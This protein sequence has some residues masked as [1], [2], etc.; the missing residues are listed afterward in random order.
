METEPN[1]ELTPIEYPIADGETL[2]IFTGAPSGPPCVRDSWAEY[3]LFDVAEEATGVSI[4]WDE[5]P[6]PNSAEQLSLRVATGDLPDLVVGLEEVSGGLISAYDNGLI[7]DLSDYIQTCAP[8]YYTYTRITNDIEKDLLTDEGYE[9]SIH[10]I[11][12][13]LDTFNGMCLRKDWLDELGLDIPTTYNELYEVMS[14]I[15]NAYNPKEPISLDSTLAYKHAWMSAGYGVGNYSVSSTEML[16]SFYLKDGGDTVTIALLDEDYKDYISMLHSWYEAGF[17]TKDFVS[18][19][20]SENDILQLICG[21]DMAMCCISTESLA[22]YYSNANDEDFELVP[23]TLISED[24]TEE[25]NHF[26]LNYVINDNNVAVTTNCDDLELALKWINYWYTDEGIMLMNYGVEGISY[27]K[28]ADGSI[29]FTDVIVNNP[30]YPTM[31]VTGMLM[32]YN[33]QGKMCGIHM[34]YNKDAIYTEAQLN[35]MKVWSS[36]LDNAYSM[37]FG[38]SLTTEESSK[39]TGTFNDIATYASEQLLAFVTGDSSMDEWDRFVDT[40]RSMGLE[41]CVE[42]YQ[43]AYD[44]YCQRA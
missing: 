42:V 3:E 15:V 23:L 32:R 30:E 36:C 19:S 13:G 10:V 41:E 33:C 5:V 18:T 43:D 34:I 17:V 8:D 2:S 24:G 35:S 31:S 16:T 1:V 39:I 14:A 7:Y 4:E 27:T 28:E 20:N 26:C 44:R 11:H 40:I 25:I 29:A 12:D 21:N 37:P 22:T 6:L 9:L 38:V